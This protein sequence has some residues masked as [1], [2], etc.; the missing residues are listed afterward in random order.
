MTPL[1]RDAVRVPSLAFDPLL[2]GILGNGDYHYTLSCF[3]TEKCACTNV[4]WFSSV[5][6]GVARGPPHVP[7]VTGEL[8]TVQS[9]KH[10]QLSYANA[11][12]ANA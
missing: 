1:Q 5:G 8:T 2:Q 3:V 11:L 4:L 9:T 6:V 10:T 7:A 12:I